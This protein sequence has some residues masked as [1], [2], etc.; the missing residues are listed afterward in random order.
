M[1]EE[2]HRHNYSAETIRTYIG[3]AERFARCFAKPADQLGPEH[4]RQYQAYL[5]HER[6]LAVGTVV[7]QVAGLRFFFVR[8]RKRRFPPDTIPYPKHTKRRMPKVFAMI[9]NPNG[10]RL[11][12]PSVRTPMCT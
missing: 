2:L 6:K 8:T 7:T 10:L 11:W 1:L 4:I 3:A 12:T 5:L 9:E